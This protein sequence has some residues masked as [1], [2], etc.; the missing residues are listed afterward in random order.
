MEGI[1]NRDI[2]FL[3]PKTMCSLH[4]NSIRNLSHTLQGTYCLIHWHILT[5]VGSPPIRVT[6][7]AVTIV[8]RQRVTIKILEDKCSISVPKYERLVTIWVDVPSNL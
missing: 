8:L 3:R 7:A 2:G 5:A 4:F 1:R 6:S